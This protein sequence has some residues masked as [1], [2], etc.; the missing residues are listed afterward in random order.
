[1]RQRCNDAPEAGRWR[2]AYLSDVSVDGAPHEGD[3][4][5][6]DVEPRHGIPEEEPAG[7]GRGRGYNTTQYCYMINVKH[8]ITHGVTEEKPAG[9]G[10]GEESGARHR[11]TSLV[12]CSDSQTRHTDTVSKHQHPIQYSVEGDVGAGTHQEQAMATAVFML[13]ATLKVSAEVVWMT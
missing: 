3:T 8:V 6:Q 4:A 2:A 12:N 9:A 13:P 11:C 7:K 5:A 1:M 10:R